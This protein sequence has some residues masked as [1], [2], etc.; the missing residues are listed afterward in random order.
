MIPDYSCILNEEDEV[1]CS[2]KGGRKAFMLIERLFLFKPEANKA[3]VIII[4]E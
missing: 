4:M 2:G 3:L 1:V